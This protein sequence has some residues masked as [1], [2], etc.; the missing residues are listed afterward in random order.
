MKNFLDAEQTGNPGQCPCCG[1]V[2]TDYVIVQNPA[3]IEAWCNTCGEF[4]N[5]SYRGTPPAGRKVMTG[6][7]YKNSKP[8]LRP[9]SS[10]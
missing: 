10:N 6:D 4:Q 1:S 2:N 3:F 7:E 8:R 9:L 5:I